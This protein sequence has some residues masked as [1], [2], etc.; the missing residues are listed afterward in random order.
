MDT[1][2]V[3]QEANHRFHQKIKHL[4]GLKMIEE[5]RKLEALP[6]CSIACSWDGLSPSQLGDQVGARRGFFKWPMVGSLKS[7]DLHHFAWLGG[8]VED[9]TEAAE[10][11]RLLWLVV[12]CSSG[13]MKI[14][15][16]LVDA[17]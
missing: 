9:V 11:A 13:C 4:R 15:Q 5:S 14:C 17:P 7:S 1:P 12:G 8:R 16:D 2:E 3:A 10:E 6:E